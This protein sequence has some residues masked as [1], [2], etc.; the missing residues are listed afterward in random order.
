MIFFLLEDG[1]EI[2]VPSGDYGQLS[3]GRWE[4]PCGPHLT[5]MFKVEGNL[6]EED[7]S[8]S[9]NEHY[10]LHYARSS[11]TVG[12]PVLHEVYRH[13]FGKPDELRKHAPDLMID[14]A[15]DFSFIMHE[16]PGKTVKQ[17]VC[18]NAS[19]ET[20][21]SIQM[22]APAY[23]VMAFAYSVSRKETYVVIFSNLDVADATLKE[24]DRNFGTAMWH[25]RESRFSLEGDVISRFGKGLSSVLS[26]LKSEDY[27]LTVL[28]P[29]THL[30]IHSTPT[31]KP[32][33]GA[34]AGADVSD[35][36]AILE[37][38]RRGELV[39]MR[40]LLSSPGQLFLWPHCGP[41][42]GAPVA[43]LLLPTSTP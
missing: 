8:S 33:A 17:Y 25:W 43:P 2:F 20:I 35:P 41:K 18:R 22:D 1:T 6:T 31:L 27:S 30:A 42:G 4:I 37:G 26:V 24:I 10:R 16:K 15:S 12:V 14:R 32:G 29:R 40:E 36:V 9:K 11:A 21:K 28:D 19:V 7:T 39:S 3:K 13:E 5:F 38:E 23:P 34:G